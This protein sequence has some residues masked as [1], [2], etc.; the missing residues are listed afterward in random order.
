MLCESITSHGGAKRLSYIRAK[1]TARLIGFFHSHLHIGEETA[2]FRGVLALRWTTFMG[3]CGRQNKRRT[4]SHIC[5]VRLP[6]HVTIPACLWW[7]LT[8]LALLT[9]GA[10]V[11]SCNDIQASCEDQQVLPWSL[12]QEIQSY[13]PIVNK[14]IKAVVYG[15]EK[16][17]TYE[18]LAMFVDK[19]GSRFTGTSNLEKSI[20]YLVHLLES[21]DFDKVYTEPVAVPRWVRGKEGAQMRYPRLKK[22]PIL[23]LG[24]S[25]GTGHKGVTAKVFVV[26]SFSELQKY[27][28]QLKGKIVVFNERY[29]SYE[30]TV[31]YRLHGPSAAAKVG[32]VAA[33]VRSVTPLSIASPHGGNTEYTRGVRK[34]P[35]AA[36]T[37]EDAEL[38]KRLQER[39]ITPVVKLVMDAKF[40]TSTF[41]LNTVAEIK[42]HSFDDEVVIVGGHIDS[43]DVGQGAMDD[44]G[45]AFVSV[46][47]LRVLRRLGLRPRRTVRC[48]LW[49]GEEMGYIGGKRYFELHGE[50]TM[51]RVNIAMES[52]SG[53]FRPKGLGFT[54]RSEE[55]KCIIAE[56]LSLFRSINASELTLGAETPDLTE[57]EKRDVPIA[58]LS[59]HNER[60][61]YFHHTE[62]DTMTVEDPKNLDLCTALWAGV[63]YVLADLRDSL[64]RA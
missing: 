32:A 14:I 1:K 46:Q 41:S 60:Y 54:G 20:D 58:S 39:G 40:Q 17:R 26:D 3:K 47:S 10:K 9:C 19:F 64:P 55:A 16:N 25:V 35:A 57:W 5:Q 28:H 44:G 48:V 31:R 34:I 8:A 15:S 42:G 22:L 38:L 27:R 29:T 18:E 56:V 51:E 62:G 23:G 2:Y 21:E 45:G 61:F 43:W 52:D 37:V 13:A 33:L 50:E 49:T 12:V 63:A 30:E 53:T 59:T 7:L 6:P 24:G 36:I 11:I 4:V